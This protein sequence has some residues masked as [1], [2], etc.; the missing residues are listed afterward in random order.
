MLG[1]IKWNVG[2][3]GDSR[4][5]YRFYFD[6]P[7]WN[8][9]PKKKQKEVYEVGNPFEVDFYFYSHL[10]FILA[11]FFLIRGLTAGFNDLLKQR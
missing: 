5:F 10:N 6:Q 1:V 3:K 7:V 8:V 9:V 11:L 2:S 4:Y